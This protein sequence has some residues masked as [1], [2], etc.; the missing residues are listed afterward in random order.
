M[1][2]SIVH[3]AVRIIAVAAVVCA[4][5]VDFD[6]DPLSAQQAPPS[7]PALRPPTRADILRGEYGRHRANNDLLSYQLDI[8]ID[9]EKKWISGKNTIR[10][11]MLKDD[12]RIQ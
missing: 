5:L 3:Q 11:R 8:R 10:F 2:A 9:P 1:S 4:A 12:A 7:A 6:S